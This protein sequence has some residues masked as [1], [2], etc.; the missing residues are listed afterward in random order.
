M[1]LAASKNAD[2]QKLLM[3]LHENDGADIVYIFMPNDLARLLPGYEVVDEP[4]GLVACLLL[5]V[6]DDFLTYFIE[7]QCLND[8]PKPETKH[9]EA[10][11]A[12][13]CLPRRPCYAIRARQ[14]MIASSTPVPRNGFL[15]RT[16]SFPAHSVLCGRP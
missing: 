16:I 3:A 12:P 1:A 14:P 13:G 9:P 5:G 2:Y 11:R 7:L 8:Q 10:L 6:E 4:R 15:I